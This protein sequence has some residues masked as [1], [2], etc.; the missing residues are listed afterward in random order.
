MGCSCLKSNVVIKSK[1]NPPEHDLS[2]QNIS[3]NNPSNRISSHHQQSN[4]ANNNPPS[5]QPP[6]ATNQISQPQNN[7]QLNLNND[8]ANLP[9][10]SNPNF[11]PYLISKNDP[12]FNFPELPNEYLGHGLKRMKGY[13]SAITLEKLQKVRDDFW[14]SRIE[15]DSEVW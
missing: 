7:H 11:E 3:N 12:S 15:G 4:T 13:I 2:S 1:L 8:T 10:F 6:Q 5:S 9:L 14:T